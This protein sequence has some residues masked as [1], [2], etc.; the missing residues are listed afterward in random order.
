M[1]LLAAWCSV[2]KIFLPIISSTRLWIHQR[3]FNVKVSKVAKEVHKPKMS[4]AW[5]GALRRCQYMLTLFLCL[6]LGLLHCSWSLDNGLQLALDSSS[7]SHKCSAKKNNSFRLCTLV[8]SLTLISSPQLWVL[9]PTFSLLQSYCKW[10][11][12]TENYQL[13]AHGSGCQ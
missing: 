9:W 10:T 8:L 2:L 3:L 4:G 11:G 12:S 5:G 1:E 6:F 13:E 7:H